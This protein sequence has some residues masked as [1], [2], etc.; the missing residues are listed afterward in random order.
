MNQRGTQNISYVSAN[1]DLMIENAIQNKSMISD[2]I[3]IN[4]Q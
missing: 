2:N 3:C 1:V 4:N